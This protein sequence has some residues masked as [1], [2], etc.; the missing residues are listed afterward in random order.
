MIMPAVFIGHGSPMN[1]IESNVYTEAWK[2][3]AA[4]VPVPRAIIAVSAHWYVPRTAVTAMELPRTIHDFTGFPPELFAVQYPAPGSPGVAGEVIDALGPR[5]VERDVEA[6]GIDH[7]T[8][9]VLVQMYPEASVP[10]V[11][12]SIDSRLSFEEHLDLGRR[13]VPLREEGVM[14]LASGNVVHNLSVMDWSDPDG[15]RDWARTFDE[16]AR[17]IMTGAPSSLPGI[18]AHPDFVRAVPTPEHFIPLLYVAGM[19]DALGRAAEVMVRGC[20]YGSL[21]MTSYVVR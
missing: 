9:S 5:V 20:A 10:V 12:L 1:A 16:A 17:D 18:T 13:L 14:V 3:F 11:Q 8:W 4:S 6:W 2:G 15:G 21:S 19:A 7:G